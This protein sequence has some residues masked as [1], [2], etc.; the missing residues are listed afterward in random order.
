MIRHDWSIEELAELYELPLLELIQKAASVHSQY[1]PKSEVQ[2]AHLISVRTGGCSED[3]KYCAQSARYKTSVKAEPMLDLKEVLQRAKEA[4]EYGATRIC[5]GAAWRNVRDNRQFEQILE[6]VSVICEMG[7]EVCCTLGMLDEH[8]AKR[9]KQAGLYAYNH[10][11]D[12]SDRFYPT[13]IT[14]RSYQDRLNTLAHVRSANISVCCGGIIGLGETKEDRL[15]LIQTLSSFHPHP[16]SVPINRLTAIQGTPLGNQPE[17][18]VWE[19]I[20]TIAVCRI[21]MP[22]SMVRLS[23][24]RERMTIAEQALC[25]LAGVNSLHWGKKLLTVPNQ[26]IDQDQQMFEIL[27]LKPQKAYAKASA[28]SS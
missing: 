21:A 4:K 24:G 18:S 5:L 26:S 22:Q 9:L 16:E 10:N 23:A 13:I 6:M 3:C 11:L 17:I 1:H 28:C 8:Q 12:T 25:F 20:K 19:L 7:L 27:K 2:I 15:R 14:T